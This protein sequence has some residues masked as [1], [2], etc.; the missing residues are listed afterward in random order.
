MFIIYIPSLQSDAA[1]GTTQPTRAADPSQSTSN[2]PWPA[3]KWGH[4]VIEQWKDVR[5]NRRGRLAI[6][7][8]C[9]AGP[10]SQAWK[11]MRGFP[12]AV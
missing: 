1:T 5:G 6:S 12:N 4:K 11:V 10:G 3:K 2:P 9:K 8:A 7:E